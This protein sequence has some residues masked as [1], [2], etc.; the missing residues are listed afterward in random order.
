LH[1]HLAYPDIIF[2]KQQVLC[3]WTNTEENRPIIKNLTF[4]KV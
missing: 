3:I 1:N 2:D 4:Y